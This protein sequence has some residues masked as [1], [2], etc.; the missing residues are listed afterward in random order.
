MSEEDWVRAVRETMLENIAN[1]KFVEEK[2]ERYLEYYLKKHFK[3]YVSSVNWKLVKQFFLDGNMMI[4]EFHDEIKFSI[5]RQNF[6]EK[7]EER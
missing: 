3:N 2:D 7:C 1:P 6:M 4:S 5:A